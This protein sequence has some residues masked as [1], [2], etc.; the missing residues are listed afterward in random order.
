MCKAPTA[1]WGLCRSAWYA[2]AGCVVG[3]AMSVS[4]GV[5]RA[6]VGATI[7]AGVAWRVEGPVEALPAGGAGGVVGV[8][9]VL[10]ERGLVVRP[11]WGALKAQLGSAPAEEACPVVRASASVIVLPRPDGEW[12]RFAFVESPIMEPGLRA[13]FPQMKTYLGQGLDNPAATVRFD[14]T[15]TGFHA[16]VLAPS[17]GGVSQDYYLDPLWRLDTDTH[18]SYWGRDLPSPGPMHCGTTMVP[19]PPDPRGPAPFGARG[20]GGTVTRRDLRIAVACTGEFTTAVSLPGAPNA[21]TAFSVVVTTISRVNLIFERDCGVRLVLV[22]G[23]NVVYTDPATDPYSGDPPMSVYA[24]QEG[25]RLT[26]NHANLTTVFGAP[27]FDLGHLLHWFP[28]AGFAGRATGLACGGA[29]GRATS[30]HNTP[31]GDRFMVS[32]VAHEIGHQLGASHTFNA[33]HNACGNAGQYQAT[34]AYEP[35]SGTTIM[36]YAGTCGPSDVQTFPGPPSTDAACDPMFNFSSILQIV[37]YVFAPS[38]CGT[39][40]A[41][42]N[43]PPVPIMPPSFNVPVNTPFSLSAGASDPD[44]GNALTYSWEQADLGSQRNLG[45]DTGAGEPLFRVFLPDWNNERWFPRLNSVLTGTAVPGE[46]PVLQPRSSSFRLILR[47]N[48]AGAGGLGLGTV[49]VQFIS[50]GPTTTGFRV[51]QPTT[52]SLC[53]GSTIPV[54][55]T[56]SDTASTPISC[57]FVDITM[58]FDGGQTFPHALAAGIAN[59]GLALVTLPPLAYSNARIKVGGVGNIFYAVN[60]GPL[61]VQTT[62]P[63]FTG[64]TAWPGCSTCPGSN[65]SIIPSPV[66]GSEP[67]Q[68]ALQKR[69]GGIWNDAQTGVPGDAFFFNP[70]QRSHA[71]DYRIV[72]R[73]ACGT[74]YST[75][76]RIEVGVAFDAQPV[77][78]N[79]APCSPAVFSVQARGVCSVQY[80]WFRDGAV[81]PNGGRFSGVSTPTLTIGGVGGCRYEDEGSYSCRVTDVCETRESDAATLLLTTPTWK[82]APMN[83]APQILGPGNSENWMSAYDESRGVMVLYGGVTQTGQTTNSLWEYDGYTWTVRQNGYPGVVMNAGQPLFNGLWPP[84]PAASAMVYNPDDSKVYLIAA[85]AWN[86]PLAICTWNGS[87]WTRPYFGPVNGDTG[88]THA[89]YDRANRRIVIVRMIGAGNTTEMLLYD[90]A[91][92]TM[93]GPTALQPQVQLG[94]HAARLVYDERR[95]VCVWYNNL[96]EF[97]NPSMWTLSGTTWTI[98]PMVPLRFGN[99]TQFAF[100]PVRYQIASMGGFWDGVS[101]YTATHGWPGIAPWTTT[102]QPFSWGTVLPDGPPRNPAGTGLSPMNNWSPLSWSTMAFDRKRRA[103]V[104]AGLENYSN[105]SGGPPVSWKTWERRYLDKVVLDKPAAAVVLAPG[106]VVEFRS[107]AAGHPNLTFQWKKNGTNLANGPAAGGGTW[108]GVQSGVMTLTG[109]G[110]AD[111]GRYQCVISN[112]C[113]TEMTAVVQLGCAG[114]FNGVGGVTVA[115]IFGFL[116][117]WFANDPAADFNGSGTVTVADIFAFLTGWFAGCP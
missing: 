75:E 89:V 7:A 35:G 72:A 9:W 5:C 30:A 100:D 24:T 63:Q 50:A 38:A 34:T 110:P 55:W 40:V 88:R 80:Q 109:V 49:N 2:P 52:G 96:N 18:V 20:P 47:D 83:A 81:L 106:N 54:I 59:S 61:L 45:P 70:I 42:S 3:L 68:I 73:N 39:N 107:Y 94:V 91:T 48:V 117:A 84:N 58:S 14:V 99:F 44:F 104:A 67:M 78:Q 108:S 46:T 111:D 112:A 6:D 97:V 86:Y 33:S 92:N 105:F 22:S 90:P 98:L 23:T 64:F 56:V 11:E 113:G 57:E 21:T 4:T 36:S 37:A 28:S 79:I 77:N 31:S 8:R 87:T 26:E 60:P 53:A 1:L 51:T 17:R 93:T 10:P 15:T 19:Q 74:A 66:S 82:V 32:V 102:L 85:F 62:A 27:G 101:W 16:M 71:G 116:S 114:D 65:V 12:E 25:A 95:G 13:Q 76:R 69:L 41:T 103:M 29:K 43:H 115:D